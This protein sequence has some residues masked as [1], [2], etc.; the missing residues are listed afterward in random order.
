M[1]ALEAVQ[2]QNK[3]LTKNLKVG[4]VWLK[5]RVT[6]HRKW[7][8][9]KAHYFMVVLPAKD[10]YSHPRTLEVVTSTKAFQIDDDIDLI[11]DVNGY[12]R[13]VEYK[14]KAT[15]ELLRYRTS[16]ISLSVQ[17]QQ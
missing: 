3:P 4:E 12:P 9:G 1:S 14:D 17:D 13:Q 2:T 7:Q 6:G 16:D 15:G 11:C 10:A 5:G 8:N